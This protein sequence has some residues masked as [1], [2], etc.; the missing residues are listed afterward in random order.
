M[1]VRVALCSACFTVYRGGPGAGLCRCVRFYAS[2]SLPGFLFGYVLLRFAVVAWL[3][4]CMPRCPDVVYGS[5]GPGCPVLYALYYI[6]LCVC[7]ICYIKSR[8]S[9]KFIVKFVQFNGINMHIML[10]CSTPKTK[11]YLDFLG[12]LWYN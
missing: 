3:R 1:C 5:A 2:A 4:L 6:R 9:G 7:A 11:I 10:N 8:K 12:L